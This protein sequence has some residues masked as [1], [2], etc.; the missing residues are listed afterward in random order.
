MDAFNEYLR[1]LMG[2]QD[3]LVG[4]ALLAASAAIEYV[5]PPFPGDFIVILGAV[6]V[7]GYGWSFAA[8][9]AAV[10]LGS[11]VGAFAAYHAG[12]VWARRR[13]ADP[14]PKNAM[15]EGVVEKFRRY[16]PAFIMVNRFLPGVRSFI[17]IGA[18]LAGMS[19][20]KVILYSAVSALLWNLVLMGIGALVG[21]NLERLEAFVEQYTLIAGALVVVVILVIVVVVLRRRHR[22]SPDTLPR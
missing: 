11:I 4:L 5:F 13:A 21:A 19:R 17:F 9:L 15:L 7:T 10:M 12:V 1:S 18:G 16:G 8:V 14:T 3:S 2:E 6:L 22:R 20:T